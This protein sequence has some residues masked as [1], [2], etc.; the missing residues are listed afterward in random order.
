MKENDGLSALNTTNYYNQ[1][2]GK[3]LA[4]MMCEKRKRRRGA[5]DGA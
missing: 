2:T 5:D 1:V 3:Q 4:M